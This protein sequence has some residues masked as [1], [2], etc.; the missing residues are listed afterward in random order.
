MSRPRSPRRI[1][2]RRSGIRGYLCSGSRI[3]LGLVG[4]FGD[5]RRWVALEFADPKMVCLLLSPQLIKSGAH[6]GGESQDCPF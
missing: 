6:G 2:A 4:D 5:R 1:G 3:S